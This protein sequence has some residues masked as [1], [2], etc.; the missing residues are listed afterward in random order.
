MAIKFRDK[1]LTKLQSPEQLDEPQRILWQH[2]R[3]AYSTF[4]LVVVLALLWGICGRLPKTGRGQGILLTP[5]AVV[6]IQAQADGQISQWLVKVGDVVQ[7]GEILGY[8]EQA[9]LERQLAQAQGK[10][11][12]VMSQQQLLKALRTR[13]STL[14]LE[15]IQRQR[16]TLKK[17][18]AYLK[19][20]NEQTR[21][22]VEQINKLNL[23]LLGVQ[24]QNLTTA[25]QAAAE[26]TA[27]LQKR[28]ESFQRLRAENLA[29]ED[30][31]RSVRL[32]YNTSQTRSRDLGV[33]MQELGVQKVQIAQTFLDAR[34]LVATNEHTIT[35]LN[36]QMQE[37]DNRE[38]QLRK[39]D[40]EAEIRDQ[41]EIDDLRR[42][43]ERYQQ[44]L[45]QDREI[46]TE[47][48]GRI[49]EVTAAEGSV[50]TFGQRLLQL[51]TRRDTDEL[52]ALAYFQDK[53]GK[54]LRVG[55]PVRV[56]PLTLDQKRYGSIR[57]E[58][59]SVSEYPITTEAVVHSVGNQEVADKLTRGGYQIEAA[60]QLKADPTTPSGYA[61]TSRRGPEV[62]I[63]SGTTADV[64]VT[65]EERAPISFILPKVR[66]WSGLPLSLKL[67]GK[68]HE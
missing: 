37:L 22:F 45:R 50:V 16:E 63:T 29:S 38:V 27:E 32:R 3:L 9:A 4:L 48:A 30:T 35:Q 42:T 52:I 49:L 58:I 61:W 6:P 34:N 65:Y 36:L 2:R 11:Q 68:G 25:S 14:E 28:L 67:S 1:A 41:N 62:D 54:Y 8:L 10:L 7:K 20:Y 15:A 33:Q 12:E 5:N 23:D 21:A 53:I 26:L 40:S 46:R 55:M 59:I 43:I 19:G 18:M 51:D 24:K 66:E 17:R 39:L 56:S 47:Y 57:G 64:W 60:V 13:Y 44:R 31:L